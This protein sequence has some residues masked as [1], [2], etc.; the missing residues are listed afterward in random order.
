MGD[1]V[2][3]AILLGD[4]A[5]LVKSMDQGAAASAAAAEEMKKSGKLGSDALGDLGGAGAGAGKDLEKL[6]KDADDSH[7]H[8]GK[9]FEDMGNWS[10]SIGLPFGNKFKEIG[11]NFDEAKSKGNGL[12]SAL[13][14][15][16]GTALAVGVVGLAA[17]SA[18]SVHLA[19][20]WQTSMTQLVTGAGESEKNISLVSKGLL[21]MASTYGTSTAQLAA[22]M[23]MA[24]SA[25]YHGA[26][27]LS[28]MAAAAQGAKVGNAD[29]GDVTN[30]VT[31]ALH[32][33]G[34]SASH[35]TGV[36]SALVETVASGKMHMSDLTTS[37]GTVLPTA[38]ALGLKFQDVTGAIATMTAAGMSARRAA[39]GLNNIFLAIASP[40]KVAETSMA[41]VGLTAQQVKDAMSE[42]GLG[43]ALKLIEQHVGDKFPKS[44]VAY[45]EAMKNIVGG[46]TGY[47]A[48]LMLSG[49]SAK[50]YQANVDNIGHSLGTTGTKVQGF[51]K[52][53]GD[54]GFQMDQV[55]YGA[56][57]MATKFG[58][59]L[60][61]VV[62]KIVT[63]GEK[64]VNWLFDCKPL[65]YTVA[66]IIAGVLVTSI[67]TWT[68]GM[69]AGGLAAVAAIAPTIA[70]G[71][72]AGS[73]A[74]AID[75]AV[76]PIAAVVAGLAALAIGAYEVYKHWNVIW[77][78]LKKIAGDVWHGIEDVFHD[79]E[80]FLKQWGPLIG[81]AILAPMTGG[82]SLVL[83]LVI[84]HWHDIVGFFEGIPGD[85]TSAL[86]SIVGD[87]E[88]I[89]TDAWHG[90]ESA[91]K[92][93]ISAVEF[94]FVGFPEDILK[95][96][97]DVGSLLLNAGHMI[98]EGLVRGIKDAAGDVT[99][100]LGGI[101]HDALH[102]IE[103]PLS[104]FSPSQRLH[105]TGEM[106]M[107]GLRNGIIDNKGLVTSALSGVASDA[108]G[109]KFDAATTGGASSLLS[110]NSGTNT[111]GFGTG[112]ASSSSQRPTS[113]T[114]NAETNADPHQIAAQ[115]AWVL[116]T[117]AV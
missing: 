28:V 32:D 48:E 88:R 2:L 6:G 61:P 30:V 9:L 46:T 35:A 64:F 50:I 25:G 113:V 47:R 43:G 10:S 55:R 36:T 21:G 107:V 80:T 31:S 96:L 58:T 29:L 73:A 45:V 49:S 98:I 87:M 83:E 13:S 1:V 108:A 93:G 104:I 114:V 26:Q 72:A 7:S 4:S 62:E 52:I 54:L 5:G 38:A 67:A 16:G 41:S 85:I 106:M 14:A 22:G 57:A 91:V 109:V 71:A 56:E 89:A 39:M 19:T 51:S 17:V 59:A 110:Q 3:R 74:L 103:N 23:Y 112:G 53:Q 92:L 102:A 111:Q 76:L 60:I 78:E 117:A 18:A 42:H 69:V 11:N 27:G 77:P 65:L 8:L 44:S 86:S 105:W 90:F 94:Y 116:K 79:F 37:I 15:I 115:V 75:S 81:A 100:A 20:S 66:G 97:G 34:L 70:F 99:H 33:Y 68:A 63:V 84:T 12:E 40:S 95:W 82:M 24:E 101:A